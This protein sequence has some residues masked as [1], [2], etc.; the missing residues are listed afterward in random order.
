MTPKPSYGAL[1][2]SEWQIGDRDDKP[3]VIAASQVLDDEGV[4]LSFKAV[5]RAIDAYLAEA[6]RRG[7]KR[8]A[9]KRR[10][11][12]QIALAALIHLQGRDSLADVA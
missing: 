1:P 10:T 7:W 5:Q 2:L 6:E 11:P 3:C 9:P 4:H 12:V 8:E